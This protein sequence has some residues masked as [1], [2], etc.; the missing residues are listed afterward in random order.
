MTVRRRFQFVTNTI[1]G[2]VVEWGSATGEGQVPVAFVHGFACTAKRADRRTLEMLAGQSEIRSRYSQFLAPQLPGFG[3]SAPL[4]RRASTVD[5]YADWYIQLLEALVP[6]PPVV[7]FGE[8][9]GGA[10]AVLVAAK[11]PDLVRSLMTF[12][13]IGGAMAT[14]HRLRWMLGVANMALPGKLATWPQY[15]SSVI[16]AALTL[17]HPLVM[18]HLSADLMSTNLALELPAIKTAGI[19]TNVVFSNRDPLVLRSSAE[20]FR[21]ALGV[22]PIFVE[23]DHRSFIEQHPIIA[24]KLIDM[25]TAEA[26][27]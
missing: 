5:N 16:D 9:L 8:S 1:G 19:A 17:R 2:R 26:R 21:D 4:D 10:V 22:E 25:L 18:W 6:E 15:V 14:R 7:L 23:G 13:S 12:N 27:R 24:E 20:T 3:G 11:R